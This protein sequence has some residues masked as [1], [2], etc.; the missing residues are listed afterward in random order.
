[1]D[2]LFEI[3]EALKEAT[4]GKMGD[5]ATDVDENLLE[6]GLT[7]HQIVQWMIGVEEALDIEFPD[8]QLH[9]QTFS[10]ISSVHRAVEA[11]VR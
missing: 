7:S 8:D 6:A 1:M 2:I 4:Q 11:Q 10:S 3:R 5:R 9:R